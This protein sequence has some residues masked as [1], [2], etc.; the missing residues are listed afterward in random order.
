[1]NIQVNDATHMSW[2]AGGTQDLRFALRSLWRYRG[3]SSAAILTLALGIGANVSL[4][5][6][7][8]VELLRP[9]PFRD[10]N[11]LV[12]AWEES[13]EGRWSRGQVSPAN[14][15]DWRERLTTFT[16]LAAYTDAPSRVSLSGHGEPQL[17]SSVNVT[18]N[19]FSVLGVRPLVGRTFAPEETWSTGATVAMISERLW[20][21]S[22]GSDLA[23]IGRTVEI[24]G[25]AVQVAGVMP[26]SFTFPRPDTDVWMATSWLPVAR[27]QAW[28]RS[29]HWLRVVG[30]L[31]QEVTPG[32]ALADLGGVAAQLEREH[33]RTNRATIVGVEPLH[34]FVVG[35]SR[36]PL[37]LTY[38][39]VSLLLLLAC[40]NTG[41][42]ILV[43]ASARDHDSAVRLAL[44]AQPARLARQA[45]SECFVIATFGALAGLLLAALILRMLGTFGP[46]D[47]LRTSD[48]AL[49]WRSVGYTALITIIGSLVFGAA[50][51][52]LA[53][54]RSPNQVLQEAGRGVTIG[55]RARRWGESLVAMEIA[56]ALWLA[57]GAGL[58]V[59]SAW[60]L[61]Q[62]QPGFDPR[63]VV[64]ADIQLPAARYSTPAAAEAFFTELVTS[65]RSRPGITS[66][67]LVSQL[68]LTGIDQTGDVS[69]EGLMPTESGSPVARR[70]I[71]SE[72]FRTMGVPLLLGRDFAHSDGQGAA[73]VVA[74]NEAFAQRHG[75]TGDMVGRRVAFTARPDS[76]TPWHIVVGV[77]GSERQQSLADAPQ[78][79][80]FEP[81]AQSRSSAMHIVVRADD[82]A[83]D[84]G[85]V[86]RSS[87]AAID[88]KVALHEIRPMA[89]VVRRMASRTILF[90]TLLALFALVGTV[91]ALVGVYSVTAQFAKARTRE[92]GIRL[93]LGA[94]ASD[95]R[96]VVLQRGLLVLLGGALCGV[97]AAAL[98]SRVL[99]AMLFGVRPLSIGTYVS[100]SAMMV[101]AGV[102][103]SLIPAWRASRM[104][105]VSVLRD[106]R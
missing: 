15:L 99:A 70:V 53:R 97:T 82:Q 71:S 36:M 62:V 42:L 20:H 47:L 92:L 94:T 102:V 8:D 78:P 79:E 40:V 60:R 13:G 96:S 103:A 81:F 39:G 77:V 59:E 25:S 28:F 64:T 68:S 100:V 30:R 57:V 48:I 35:E 73:R 31:R 95:I 38:A 91:L 26:R 46:V 55:R 21:S 1:M 24:D 106:A 19:L 105:P 3:T 72:Y 12:V 80:V 88:P 66:A 75:R 61:R 104:D 85:R 18:G 50:A 4:F 83:P 74:V 93:A 7:V 32:Q 63:G 49:H 29:A 41:N 34:Q 76:A 5:T 16:D 10:P 33:P 9:L 58:L 84:I 89:D 65:V 69:V 23:L 27:S 14:Y 22:F 54:R 90:T 37:W 56:I 101:V 52:I 17:I 98:S 43:L 45:L 44:G 87:V 86:L 51:L 67:A 11:Q 6:V 2:L